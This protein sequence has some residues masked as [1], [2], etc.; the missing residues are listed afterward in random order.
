MQSIFK[1][2]LRSSTCKK[3]IFFMRVHTQSRATSDRIL[4]KILRDDI[5]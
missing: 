5:F 2:A 4:N 1:Y 3:E